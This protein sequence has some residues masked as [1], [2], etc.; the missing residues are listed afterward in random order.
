M[1]VKSLVTYGGKEEL[2][3]VVGGEIGL[4]NFSGLFHLAKLALITKKVSLIVGRGVVGE[5]APKFK[6][7]LIG[8]M[9]EPTSTTFLRGRGAS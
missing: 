8:E 6:L 1:S 3:N 7:T 9:G 5:F 4:F 2:L